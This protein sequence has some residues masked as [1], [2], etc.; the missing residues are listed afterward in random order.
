MIW[1]RRIGAALLAV[2]ALYFGAWWLHYP[3]NDAKSI[4]Y[5]LWRADIMPMD[6][7][8]AMSAFYGDT[9]R[10]GLV[11]GK[12]EAQVRQRFG[13]LLTPHQAGPM[14]EACRAAAPWLK[15]KALFLRNSWL[16]AVFNHGVATDLVLMKPC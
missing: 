13:Y 4:R 8:T 15:G 3:S 14:L 9:Y 12:T 10:D 5:Q 2:V 16:M 6:L 7:D 11:V 1:V